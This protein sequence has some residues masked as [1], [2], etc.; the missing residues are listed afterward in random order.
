MNAQLQFFFGIVCIQLNL[1][2][3]ALQALKEAVRLN[4]ENAPFNYALGAAILSG[5]KSGDAVAYFKKYIQL[6]PEDPHGRFALGVAEYEAR[7]KDAARRDLAPLTRDP[8]VSAGAH[9]VL[10]KICREESEYDGARGHFES[11]LK[12]DARNADLETNLAVIDIRQ[13]R[14]TEAKREL[15]RALA[16]DPNNYLAN[17]NFLSLLRKEKDPGAEHQA[18]R[19]AEV[20]QRVSEEQRL[21]LRHIDVQR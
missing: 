1:P 7:D 2:G 9:L 5:E 16:L 12:I 18:Q 17:E 10:G 14:F 6:R 8:L 21:L 3:D 19:F 15:D 4:P 13:N 20:T 11:A